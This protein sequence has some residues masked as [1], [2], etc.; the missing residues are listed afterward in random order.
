MRFEVATM[1]SAAV[2]ATRKVALGESVR[3]RGITRVLVGG[4]V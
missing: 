4:V 1:R 3:L 2:T